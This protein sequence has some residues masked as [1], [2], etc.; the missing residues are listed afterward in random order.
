[1]T[2]KYKLL[3]HPFYKSWSAGT[4]STKQ[5][6]NYAAS[7]SEFIKQIP[8]FWEKI[9]KDFVPESVEGKK[10][11]VEEMMHIPLWSKWQEKLDKVVNY[12]KMTE[13]IEELRSMNSSQLL[14]AI[15]AFEVQQP[16]VAVTKKEGLLMHYGFEEKELTY[17]DEH[18][19]EQEHIDFGKML[20]D[21]YADKDDFK[22]GFE[23][24]SELIYKG[25]DL[26]VEC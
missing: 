16:E 8:G 18:I 14:G 17:F 6:A 2:L 26:F 9:V 10:I 15:H 22:Y 19:D 12:P 13:L 4:V 3:E 20:A 24:G 11:I 7:Y 5:L 21:N 1:M 23:T 25:L